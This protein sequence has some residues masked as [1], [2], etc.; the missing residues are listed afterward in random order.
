M[1]DDDY[2]DR[3]KRI[4]GD[5]DLIQQLIKDH[6]A[7]AAEMSDDEL[8]AARE[9]K[10]SECAVAWPKIAEAQRS[11]QYPSQAFYVFDRILNRRILKAQ[12]AKAID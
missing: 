11:Y 8:L 1:K 3:P 12:I 7:I 5:N 4:A 2:N 6:E 9:A 10:R